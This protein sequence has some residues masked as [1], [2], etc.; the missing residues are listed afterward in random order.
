MRAPVGTSV[1]F[2]FQ[3]SGQ[4]EPTVIWEH[5]NEEIVT[6]PQYEV[7]TSGGVTSLSIT[8]VER[9]DEGLYTCSALNSLGSA[10]MECHLTVLG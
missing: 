1:T 7:K 8:E 2:Q 3:V 9:D 4:P 10:V 5:G 6:S